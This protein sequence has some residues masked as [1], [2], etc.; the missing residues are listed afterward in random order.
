MS[1]A[2]LPAGSHGHRLGVLEATAFWMFVILIGLVAGFTLISPNFVFLSVNNLFTIA[3]NT[4]QLAL[5]AAGMTFLLGARQM[6]LSVG[7]N[8][9]LASV[10]AGKTI[11]ALAGT[12]DEVAMGDYPNL[13]LAIAAGTAVAFLSGALF[14]AVNGVLVT[15]FR[16]SSF[17]VTL[18]TT[19]IGLGMALVITHGANVPDIPRALQTG[20][21]VRRVLGGVPMPVVIVA[22]VLAVLWFVLAKTRFGAHTLAIGS[23]PEAA[24]R[25]GIPVD[26]HVLSLFVLMGCLSAAAAM[27]DISRFAT[28]NISGHQTD[29]LQAIAA[30]VIGGTSLFGGVASMSG[31]V[32]GALIPVVLATGL[33][34]MRVDAFYQLIVVGIIVIVAVAIDQ[35]N[36]QRMSR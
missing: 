31:T 29:A 18:A 30:S 36:R 8:V 20:F 11:T 24:R 6:D 19:A 10:L 13:A 23:S 5:L 28:T 7:S 25:A 22:G 2:S 3:L 9:V 27:L 14:G 32:I 16:L 26:R 4:A 12:P 17:L 21:A 15:R 33:V 1:D 35:K 34:I